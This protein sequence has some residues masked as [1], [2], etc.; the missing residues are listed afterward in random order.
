MIYTDFI[1]YIF[2]ARTRITLTSSINFEDIRMESGRQKRYLS[3]KY[4]EEDVNEI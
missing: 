3:S 2:T 1:A 4:S